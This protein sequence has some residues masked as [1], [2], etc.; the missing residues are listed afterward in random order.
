MRTA[1]LA[2]AFSAIF[3]SFVAPASH[4]ERLPSLGA[5]TRI[6][7]T[8]LNKRFVRRITVSQSVTAIIALIDA[9][10]GWHGPAWEKP[11]GSLTLTFHSQSRT[12]G[13][14]EYSPGRLL[15]IFHER[16]YYTRL[17]RGDDE[18]LLQ[19]LDVRKEDLP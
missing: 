11:I 2:S 19:L 7:V 4:A 13:F 18:K 17:V 12:L 14:V 3:V 15:R 8:D 9:Q 10:R 6:E 1:H 16:P 5:A